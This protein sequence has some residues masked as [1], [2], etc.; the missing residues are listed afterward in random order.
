MKRRHELRRKYQV[1]S[2]Y[3]ADGHRVSV[4]TAAQP[5]CDT[6]DSAERRGRALRLFLEDLGKPGSCFARYLSSRIDLLPAEYCREFESTADQAA[7]MSHSEVSEA[8]TEQFGN[9]FSRIF[10]LFN[11]TP[12]RSSLIAECHE[13][14]TADGIS[15]LVAIVRPEFHT[16]KDDATPADLFNMRLLHQYCAELAAGNAVEDFLLSLRRKVDFA[17][18]AEKLE[19][20]SLGNTADNTTEISRVH[21]RLSTSRILTVTRQQQSGLDEVLQSRPFY[22]E[23]LASLVCQAWFQQA[24]F[25]PCF[26]VD[27]AYHNINVSE[28]G[29]IAFVGCDL[30]GLPKHARENLWRY[31]LAAA[32]DEPDRAAGFLLREMSCTVP[33][34]IDFESF[35]GSFRQ[36]ASFGVLEPLLG[37]DTNALAQLIFQHWQTTTKHGYTAG[38]AL[39]AFYRGLFLIARVARKLWPAGDPLRYALE[40]MRISNVVKQAQNFSDARFVGLNIDKFAVSAAYFPRMLDAALQQISLPQDHKPDVDAPVPRDSLRSRRSPALTALPILLVAVCALQSGPASWWSSKLALFV[41]MVAGLLA[42]RGLW[43]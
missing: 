2:R 40:E 28:G 30:E 25:G 12:I 7:P 15:V 14:E 8:L 3:Q 37:T 6:P 43:E 26:P 17:G 5:H 21:R 35:R 16:F 4:S 9:S 41:I 34:K 33:G 36:S 13:A 38:P 1:L 32:T 39:L 10:P 29:R 27:P 22:A 42:L 11:F 23:R 19:A 24:L 18:Q 20:M 31:L